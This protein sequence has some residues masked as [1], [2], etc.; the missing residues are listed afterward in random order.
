MK[1]HLRERAQD[2]GIRNM[3]QEMQQAAVA[4]IALGVFQ[5]ALDRV[6]LIIRQVP[7]EKGTVGNT[8]IITRG[9]LRDAQSERHVEVVDDRAG[10]LSEHGGEQPEFSPSLSTL[11]ASRTL[12]VYS[13]IEPAEAVFCRIHRRMAVAWG[14]KPAGVG[15]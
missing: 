10:K 12:V 9:G 4:Q 15:R 7:P 1:P 6:L 5:H 8:E 3:Q 11:G 14:K 2:V 13:K